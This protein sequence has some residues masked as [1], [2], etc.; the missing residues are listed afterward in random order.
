MAMKNF[1]PPIMP[2]TIPTFVLGTYPKIHF[3]LSAYMNIDAINTD[4]V[5][6]TVKKQNGN[7]SVINIA[8]N[9]NSENYVTVLKEDEEGYYIELNPR[10]INFNIGEYY[11][12]Q[13]R[14]LS[15]AISNVTAESFKSKPSEYLDY[16]SEWSSVCLLRPIAKP[17]LILGAFD[18]V[19]SIQQII[20]KSSSLNLKGK[21]VFLDDNEIE[22]LNSYKIYLYEGSNSIVSTAGKLVLETDFLFNSAYSQNDIDYLIGYNLKNKIRYLLKIQYVTSGGYKGEKDYYF[23]T[24][25]DVLPKIDNLQAT[26]S[27]DIVNSSHKIHIS[28]TSSEDLFSGYLVLK[29]ASGADDFTLW[30]DLQ[31]FYYAEPT[32]VNIDYDDYLIEHGEVYKYQLVLEDKNY[33]RSEP[34]DIKKV[35]FLDSSYLLK[36][37]SNELEEEEQVETNTTAI[38]CQLNT[39]SLVC[40]DDEQFNIRFDAAVSNYQ[41]TVVESKTET[42]GGKYPFIR[43]NGDTYYRQFS[44]NGLITHFCEEDELEGYN[45]NIKILDSTG[46]EGLTYQDYEDKLVNK[47][48]KYVYNSS[49][50]AELK[51][52][53]NK[54]FYIKDGDSGALFHKVKGE[55]DELLERKYREKI[56]ALLYEN[57]IRLFKSPTEGNI[58]VKLMNISL[59]PKQELNRLV[60]SFT[61]TAF[62]IDDYNIENC[63]KYKIHTLNEYDRS[64]SAFFS[65]NKVGQLRINETAEDRIKYALNYDVNVFNLVL[66]HW[67]S[68]SGTY[69]P[70]INYLNWVRIQFLSPPCKIYI[71]KSKDLITESSL[72][73]FVDEKCETTYKNVDDYCAIYKNKTRVFYQKNS[74][75]FFIMGYLL[76]VNGVQIIVPPHGYYEIAGDETK[77]DRLKIIGNNEGVVGSSDSDKLNNLSTIQATVDFEANSY[78]ASFENGLQVEY[79]YYKVG[80]INRLTLARGIEAGKNLVEVINEKFNKDTISKSDKMVSKVLGLSYLSI[81]GQPYTRVLIKDNSDAELE[82]HIL[83][84]TGILTLVCDNTYIQELYLS[85]YEDNANPQYEREGTQEEVVYNDSYLKDVIIDY[86]ALM[87]GGLY[88]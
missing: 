37:R 72:V 43:R 52:V 2:T 10:L 69:K 19:T 39:T 20:L 7:T 74:T 50:S 40:S 49:T 35:K 23:T 28:S 58:L 64:N 33:N 65:D 66:D 46:R 67:K 32:F 16:L 22:T 78:A 36:H 53:Y 76:E 30:T 29:R 45:S 80:Q 41:Y 87:Q 75:L 38:M 42:L 86:V 56:M 44:I 59:T 77:I 31:H 48:E 12:V 79:L 34:L 51:A 83:N 26:V 71:C 25:W 9:G 55:D 24:V 82:E 11:K 15:S 1:Y 57:A 62:E 61:A 47:R 85:S 88:G 6:V 3:Q 27:A 84:P 73:Y 63:I 18:I 54:H 14:F 70:I 17:N 21:L 60:Y 81:E 13:A 4:I 5:Q 8:L 68:S